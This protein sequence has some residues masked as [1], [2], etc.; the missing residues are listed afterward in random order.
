MQ[1]HGGEDAEVNDGT[2]SRRAFSLTATEL[3][4]HVSIALKMSAPRRNMMSQLVRATALQLCGSATIS[5]S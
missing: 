3:V 2:H 5:V 4:L 1:R